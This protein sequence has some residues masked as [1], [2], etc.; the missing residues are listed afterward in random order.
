MKVKLVISIVLT[1]IATVFVS[2]NTEVVQVNFLTWS[3]VIS[4]AL[5][6]FFALGTGLVIG[7]LLSSY[8]RFARNR[9]RLK[10][11]AGAQTEGAA[12]QTAS[13]QSIQ[14]EKQANES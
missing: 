5:L 12:S 9:K 13:T 10:E 11:E 4:L 2:Q 3:V 6:V 7:W 1:A 8:L 14:E